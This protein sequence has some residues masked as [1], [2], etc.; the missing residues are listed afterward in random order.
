MLAEQQV[1]VAEAF[2]GAGFPVG[3][4]E[5]DVDV[6][7]RR[8]RGDGPAGMAEPV[9]ARSD[10]LHRV[11]FA[12]PEPGRPVQLEGTCFPRNI[13]ASAIPALTEVAVTIFTRLT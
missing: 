10:A 11:G 5:L 6:H 9:R 4:A 1:G 8:D 7:R 2:P 3:V 13:K 12:D